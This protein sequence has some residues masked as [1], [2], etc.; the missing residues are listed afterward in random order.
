M[1]RRIFSAVIYAITTLALAAF[2]DG[3]YRGEPIPRHLAPIYAAT[4]GV[5]LFAVA[6]VLLLF[7]LRF[8]AICGLA[9]NVLSWPYFGLQLVTIPWGHVLEVLPYARWAETYAAILVLIISS[10]YSVS[11]LR[12]LLRA[13]AAS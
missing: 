6:S 1:K 5:A 8:G 9:A 13:P 2:F 4:A 11:H 12:F 7:S 3:L 10:A